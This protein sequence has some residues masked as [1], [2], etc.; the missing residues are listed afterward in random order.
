[1]AKSPAAVATKSNR[2][3]DSRAAAVG[4]GGGRESAGSED[5]DDSLDGG[6]LP[7]DLALGGKPRVTPARG[8]NR[9]RQARSQK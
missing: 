7:S 4:C 3:P 6:R 9:S 2:E 5:R 8:A 1:M